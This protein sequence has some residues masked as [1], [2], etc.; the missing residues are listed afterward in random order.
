MM[1]AAAY[2]TTIAMKSTMS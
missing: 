1:R 2:V